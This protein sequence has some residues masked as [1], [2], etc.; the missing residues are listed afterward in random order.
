MVDFLLHNV[1]RLKKQIN[2]ENC[3]LWSIIFCFYC[4]PI[5]STEQVVTS[6]TEVT[7][8]IYVIVHAKFHCSTPSLSKLKCSRQVLL[9]SHKIKFC[10]LGTDMVH[11]WGGWIKGVGG[12]TDR[13]TGVTKLTVALRGPLSITLP[14]K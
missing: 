4:Y 9:K 14:Y 11:T 3:R 8:Y 1:S 10:P 7:I 12:Q 2:V 6:V 13:W 5:L